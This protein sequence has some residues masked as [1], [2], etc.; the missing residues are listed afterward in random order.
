VIYGRELWVEKDDADAVEVGEKVTLMKWGN[1][2]ITKKDVSADGN[3][4][5]YGTVDE[6]DKD[7]KK[8]KKL[9]WVCADPDTTVEVTLTEFDHLINKK[10]VEENDDV[11][12][13]VNHNSRIEYTA[14]A[15]GSLRSIQRGASIQLERRGYF[16]VDQAATGQEGKKTIKLNFIP[17]GKS[18]NMSAISH[19]LDA[20][21]I[22]GGKGKADGANRA[23][24][25]KLAGGEAE[26]VPVAGEEVKELSKN[27][28]KKLQKKA[29]K[30][31]NKAAGGNEEGKDG[32]S[33]KG[34]AKGG[35][36]KATASGV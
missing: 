19:K 24:A 21:E 1:V 6:T 25:K 36:P 2:T 22:A 8:T 4:V 27:E 7:F 12:Q 35:A 9:T 30:K 34:A 11:K 17:D 3:P 10:K 28:L 5:L 14:I 13:L 29:E 15:E 31:A 18:K 26:A 23:E 33:K 20:K 16:F 32:E